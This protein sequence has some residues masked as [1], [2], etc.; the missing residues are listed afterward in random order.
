M[1]DV[2]L[3]STFT[4]GI[5]GVAA[6]GGY[7]A[8]YGGGEAGMGGAGSGSST[9]DYAYADQDYDGLPTHN[10]KL[11][12]P[13]QLEK[14]LPSPLGERALF[15]RTARISLSNVPYGS[16]QNTLSFI[17]NVSQ[18]LGAVAQAGI[19]NAKT[20]SYYL[21]LTGVVS[22]LPQPTV[23]QADLEIAAEDKDAM[24]ELLPKLLL[25]DKFP[26]ADSTNNRVK[27]PPVMV[28]LG[29][30]WR[31][32][33]L[34]PIHKADHCL[35][36]FTL[37][38]VD[39]NKYAYTDLTSEADF[40]VASG[41][42]LVYD[43]QWDAP[44]AK[45][46][47]DLRCTDGTRLKDASVNDQNGLSAALTTDLDAR[48]IGKWY[49]RQI[50]LPG[51]WSGKTISGWLLGC[52]NDT[53]GLHTGRI[54][55][56][57][58]VDGQG[59]IRNYIVHTLVP[60]LTASL[61]AA[62]TTYS[63]NAGN[64]A[65]VEKDNHWY[66]GAIRYPNNGA[67][68]IRN[69]YRAGRLVDPSGYN[70]VEFLGCRI[71]AFNA[72]QADQNGTPVA[73]H[74]DIESTEFSSIPAT[75]LKFL[76]S[77]TTYGLGKAVNAAS[78]TTAASDYTTLGYTIDGGLSD[79]K[80][81]GE[82]ISQLLL[83]GAYLDK[84]DTNE[85][86]V[87]VDIASIHTAAPIQLGEGD[88]TWNNCT[89]TAGDSLSLDTRVR[90]LTV[91]AAFDPGFTGGSERA[92]ISKSRS[93]AGAGKEE[94]VKLQFVGNPTVA[95]KEAHYLSIVLY[96]LDDG[97]HVEVNDLLDG[98]QLALNHTVKLNV[99]SMFIDAQTFCVR[100]VVAQG[101]SLKF[102]LGGY[103]ADAYTYV[104]GTEGKVDPLV[105]VAADYSQ[106]PPGAPASVSVISTQVVASSSPG[107]APQ[108]V[109]RVSAPPPS[110]NV[111]DLV[112]RLI[113]PSLGLPVA[114]AI[115][116]AVTGG[117]AQ[118]ATLIGVVGVPYTIQALARNVANLAD[119]RDGAV[120]QLTSQ[121]VLNTTPPAQ[122][123]IAELIA[124]PGQFEV[125]ITR[126]TEGDIYSYEV[127]AGLTD[128]F[129][130]ATKIGEAQEG[131]E[132]VLILNK[133]VA[134]DFDKRWYVFVRA[135]NTSG[136]IGAESDPLSAV[137]LRVGTTDV[138]ANAISLIL[139]NSNSGQTTANTTEKVVG[140]INHSG[141]LGQ[142]EFDV[143][144]LIQNQGTQQSTITV[145]IRR[146]SLT[147]DSIASKS[148]TLNAGTGDEA[149]V[150]LKSVDS[151]YPTGFGGSY[152]IT[153]RA[154]GGAMHVLNRQIIS[155]NNR[156]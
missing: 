25:T 88:G 142:I 19:Y 90:K 63:S 154:T 27:D 73:I 147:G 2:R 123:V 1:S 124:K 33:E 138:Q 84:N 121:T 96:A 156:R 58:I 112:F 149:D 42:V 37:A 62:D 155:R 130:Q 109:F 64:T 144:F 65:T 101:D 150:L 117:S 114:E 92:L 141:I 134:A 105:Y 106:T 77:D 38:G 116:P 12:A 14:H 151:A 93:R 103:D 39:V 3:I 34:T 82:I 4:L 17:R 18:I 129:S 118:E 49:R 152:V 45:I 5:A 43:V 55:N 98:V 115:A 113:L 135:K 59:R 120:V 30:L 47:V 24:Q 28:A 21:K 139:E 111:T 110:V 126:N 71:V 57:M 26:A 61:A 41:D 72:A 44:G 85:Y 70:A 100:G 68:T 83:H 153:A 20:S 87:Q 140:A 40:L 127:F 80:K 54:G 60:S 125:R 108:A 79:R 137:L 78:F 66:Y 8:G 76:L 10:A 9:V 89:V 99:P 11:L 143:N 56:V 13:I 75:A 119:Y 122:A 15:D 29:G 94:I 22:V 86:L 46:G 136:T 53:A 7:G 145:R 133:F 6:Q 35:V 104:A 132:P 51:G 48:A 81:A 32:A 36:R 91:E 128:V 131:N 102:V 74:A 31:K 69:L 95:D 52:E 107:Q 67:V 148:R 16:E 23:L 97:Y 146:D 50:A